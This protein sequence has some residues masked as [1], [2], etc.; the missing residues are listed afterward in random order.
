MEATTF[1]TK[2]EAA[3]TSAK[4]VK[5]SGTQVAARLFLN[6]G[7]EIIV[8]QN[9][10]TWFKYKCDTEL[11]LLEIGDRF[12]LPIGLQEAEPTAQNEQPTEPQ[13]GGEEQEQEETTVSTTTT[14]QKNVNYIDIESIIGFSVEYIT[15]TSAK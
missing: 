7:S 10:G 11:G 5:K 4:Q 12:T 14:Q 15:E 8:K 3:V 2:F 13:D 9:G 1:K 6:N